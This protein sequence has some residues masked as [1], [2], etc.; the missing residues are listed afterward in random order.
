[1]GMFRAIENLRSPQW[2]PDGRRRWYVVQTRARHE[3]RAVEHLR[4]RT[5]DVET[6][7]PKIEAVRR[8]AGRKVAFV[9]PLFPNYLFL[10]TTFDAATWNLVRW[11]PGVRRV[12]GDGSIPIPVPDEFIEE[13][14]RRVEPRG[15]LRIEP[16]FRPGERVFFQTGPFVGLEA[17]FERRLSRCGRMR[18]LLTFLRTVARV[19][20]DVLDL[21]RA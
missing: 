9:E 21:Q 10:R 18:V 19:D 16:I 3:Y 5:V 15:F 17:V 14:R 4:R 13:I 11:S 6:F 7:L 20:V 8:I 1:M 2:Q 12:L